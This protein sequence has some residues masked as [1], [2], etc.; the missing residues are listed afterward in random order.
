MPKGNLCN[1]DR[2]I[3]N[4]QDKSGTAARVDLHGA[5]FLCQTM[6]LLK[7]GMIVRL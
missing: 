2:F 3:S 7:S 4:K 1:L 6:A 5:S